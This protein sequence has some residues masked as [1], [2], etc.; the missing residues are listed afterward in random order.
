[1]TYSLEFFEMNN[2]CAFT[3][4][5]PVTYDHLKIRVK[6]KKPIHKQLNVYLDYCANVRQM[7]RMTMHAKESALRFFMVESHC[8]NLEE[9]TNDMYDNFVK[10]ELDR[11]IGARTVNMRTAHI[12]ALIRYYKEM[13]MDIPLRIPL[14]VKL[15]EKP[16]RRVFY[17]RAQVNL[18][19]KKCKND[20]EWLLIK[21][22]FDT[23]MRI[24]EIT[25]MTVEQLDGRRVSFIGKGSK[26]REVWLSDECTERLHQYMDNHQIS[27]GRIWLNDW[28]YPMGTDTLRRT[29][30]QAFVRCGFEDFYPH[31]LRHSFGSDIQKQGADIM[32][33][34]EM[35]GHSNIATTQKYLHSLDGQLQILFDRY[36]K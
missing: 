17:T 31:A 32:V 9:L 35:M 8:N 33:I 28:G 27:S 11:G 10:S 13:G 2:Y 29:M 18:V 1:V 7:S 26:Q 24:T 30:K 6:R 34:K 4:Y 19:L 25:N 14:V 20:L 22:A 3:K 21:I 15:K 12:V 36:K 23:G 16:P 5:Q